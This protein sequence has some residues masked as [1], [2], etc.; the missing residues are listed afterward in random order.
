MY[1]DNY[2]IISIFIIPVIEI[3]QLKIIPIPSLQQEVYLH[4]AEV[5]KKIKIDLWQFQ[6]ENYHCVPI[7]FRKKFILLLP[8]SQF[9][10]PH[11]LSCSQ[12]SFCIQYTKIFLT[13]LTYSCS[14]SA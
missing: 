4:P 11:S 14:D 6:D 2:K 12:I 9:F 7:A 5:S 13:L 8:V 3:L 10:I 1:Q